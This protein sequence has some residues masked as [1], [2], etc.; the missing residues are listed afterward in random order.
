M[1]YH[2]SSNGFELVPREISCKNRRTFCFSVSKSFIDRLLFAQLCLTLMISKS[3]GSTT[4]GVVVVVTTMEE[5]AQGALGQSMKA[6]SWQ[7]RLLSRI[8]RPVQNSDTEFQN[9]G[10]PTGGSFS[11][12][13]IS[14]FKLLTNAKTTANVVVGKNQKRGTK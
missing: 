11:L 2:K 13:I 3:S 8:F 5:D 7:Q 12:N 6:S 9:W 4:R 10:R 1:N 14:G